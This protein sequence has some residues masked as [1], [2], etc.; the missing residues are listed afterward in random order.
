MAV[1]SGTINERST[2]AVALAAVNAQLQKKLQHDGVAFL[3]GSVNALADVAARSQQKLEA[4]GL[5]FA[6]G[7]GGTVNWR[8]AVVVALVDVA[9]RSQKKL[10]AVDVSV[11]CGEK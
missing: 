8:I 9:A 5:A 11:P 6:G 7:K 3:G 2:V 4:V 1:L 10:E